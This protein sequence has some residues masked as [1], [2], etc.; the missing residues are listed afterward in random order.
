MQHQPDILLNKWIT[1]LR[2]I[3]Y[4]YL[5][6]ELDTKSTNK[7]GVEGESDQKTEYQGV[8]TVQSMQ[9]DITV[10]GYILSKQLEY[11]C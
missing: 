3:L 7:M 8:T 11:S 10:C 4:A 9:W 5:W 6:D 2:Y 1:D